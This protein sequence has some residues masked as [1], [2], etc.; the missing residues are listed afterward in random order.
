[1][2]KL[3]IFKWQTCGHKFGTFEPVLVNCTS[4]I[5]SYMYTCTTD[6]LEWPWTRLM[7]NCK[8]YQLVHVQIT[9]MNLYVVVIMANFEQFPLFLLKG[10]PARM[11]NT[12]YPCMYG[13]RA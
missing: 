3:S 5:E 1:M 9:C 12:I 7:Q 2:S 10:Q 4:F 8:M 6:K 13:A 11:G